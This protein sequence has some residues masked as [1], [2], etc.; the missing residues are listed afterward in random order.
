VQSYTVYVCN[1]I[2]LSEEALQSAFQQSSTAL[3]KSVVG[4]TRPMEIIKGTNK[5][6]LRGRDFDV[7]NIVHCIAAVAAAEITFAAAVSDIE[8]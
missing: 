5:L 1:V 2:Q 3:T 7:R 4:S 6:R 8:T